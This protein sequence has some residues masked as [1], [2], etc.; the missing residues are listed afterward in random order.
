MR[1][2]EN[3]DQAASKLG[4]RLDD[5]LTQLRSLY[6]D[7]FDVV[8]HEFRYGKSVRAALVYIAG[9]S[10]I[11]EINRMILQSAGKTEPPEKG[12]GI[13]AYRPIVPV[14]STHPVST[15]NDV[16]KEVSDGNPVLLVDGETGGLAVALASWDQRSVQEPEAEAVVRGP[17]EGFIETLQVNT[18]MLRRKLKTPSLKMRTMTI[19]KFSQTQVVIA[20]LDGVADPGLLSEMEQRLKRIQID[21]ILETGYIQEMIEDNPMS[22]FPL[23]QTTERPDIAAAHLLEG[24]IVLLVEGTPLTLIAPVSFF[25][26]LQS[27]EDYYQSFYFGTA[28]RW[29]RYLFTL[30]ALI[31]PSLYVAIITFHQEMIP[32][33]LLLSMA[34]SRELIPFPALVEALLMEVTFEALREAGVRLPKQVGAAVSIVGALVIGQAAISAGLVSSPMVMV[35]AVTGIA[36]FMIPHYTMGIAIRII[37]FPMM[38]LAGFLGFYGLILGTLFLLT[39]LFSLRSFGVPYMAPVATTEKTGLKDVLVRAPLWNMRIRPHF[40]GRW[41]KYRQQPGSSY[42]VRRRGGPK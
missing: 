11:D 28:I 37:R 29:L 13:D 14:S 23:L 10:N 17:R 2:S 33:T 18:A 41:N 42:Q 8:F 3:N 38:L 4:S 6:Q 15:P 20:Y 12:S 39:H 19:G 31:G 16:V 1:R 7:C 30:I 27:A 25:S 24:R 36:S 32:T 40:T 34:K 5:N 22:P 26:F 21:G 35:V 9:L